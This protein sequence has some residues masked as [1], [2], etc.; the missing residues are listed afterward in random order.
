MCLKITGPWKCLTHNFTLLHN[1]SLQIGN[2][3]KAIAIIFSSST[4]PSSR[5]PLSCLFPYQTIL[6]LLHLLLYCKQ[7]QEIKNLMTK[8]GCIVQP[9]AYCNM[10][11]KVN[12]CYCEESPVLAS[13]TN[14]LNLVKLQYARILRTFFLNFTKL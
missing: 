14:C 10:L 1:Y 4:I 12:S 11:L 8:R 6:L 3:L 7:H 9:P 5:S 13:S 2:I